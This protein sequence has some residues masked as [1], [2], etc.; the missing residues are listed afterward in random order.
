[1]VAKNKTL[2][3]RK[4][5][6]N[7]AYKSFVA[8]RWLKGISTIIPASLT[9]LYVLRLNSRLGDKLNFMNS[10]SDNR[11][12]A[13]MKADRDPNNDTYSNQYNQ[14]IFTYKTAKLD[15]KY[16]RR[17]GIITGSVLGAASLAYIVFSCTYKSS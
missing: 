9:V 6:H 2:Y 5:R 8:K 14:S 1:M 13:R 12:W 3:S 15:Y 4:L 16:N 11:M 17:N 7:D 10:M